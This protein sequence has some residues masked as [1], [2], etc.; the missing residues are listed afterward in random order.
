MFIRELNSLINIKTVLIFMYIF[1]IR[2]GVNGHIEWILI[3]S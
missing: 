1:Y 2:Y 3:V